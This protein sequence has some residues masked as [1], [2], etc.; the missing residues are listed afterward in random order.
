VGAADF[1][2]RAST[3]TLN[4]SCALCD[5]R[6]AHCEARHGGIAAGWQLVPWRHQNPLN[7]SHSSSGSPQPVRHP[8]RGRLRLIGVGNRDVGFHSRGHGVRHQRSSPDVRTVSA[9]GGM[10]LAGLRTRSGRSRAPSK[11]RPMV[12]NVIHGADD[13]PGFDHDAVP[14]QFEH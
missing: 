11:T 9:L 5:G 4:L 10:V 2:N 14:F 12:F 7:L 13:R 8:P 3:K 1:E 6:G